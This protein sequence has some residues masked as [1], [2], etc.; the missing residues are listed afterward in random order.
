[1]ELA[2]AHRDARG[3]DM[4]EQDCSE[5]EARLREAYP[6]LKVAIAPPA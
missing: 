3:S 2:I 5:I 6:Q 1:M 4:T